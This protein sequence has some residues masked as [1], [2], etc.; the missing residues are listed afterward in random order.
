MGKP[1]KR[2]GD[3]LFAGF[4]AWT[5]GQGT[6]NE[7]GHA[8]NPPKLPYLLQCRFS[9]PVCFCSLSQFI[10]FLLEKRLY[11]FYRDIRTVHKIL[12][13]LSSLSSGLLYSVCLFAYLAHPSQYSIVHCNH[14]VKKCQWFFQLQIVVKF[15]PFEQQ[16]G[17][18]P[19]HNLDGCKEPGML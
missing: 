9:C 3:M 18:V 8:G 13:N 5:T 4:L 7:C 14:P 17:H 15:F 10:L 2:N 16:D 11:E 6:S 1:L 19:N 12:E